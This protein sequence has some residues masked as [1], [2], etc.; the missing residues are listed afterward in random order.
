MRRL[1]ATF[2]FLLLQFPLISRAQ[3]ALAVATTS[4]PAASEGVAYSFQLQA[5]GGVPPYTWAISSGA[6]P[7]GLSLSSGGLI[8]GTPTSGGAFNFTVTVTDSSS[9]SGGNSGGGGSS[10]GGSSG[11]GGEPIFTNVQGNWGSIVTSG[12]TFSVTLPSA[13]TPGNA[14]V[15]AIMEYPEQMTFRIAD[16]ATIPNTYTVTPN[17]PANPAASGAAGASLAYLLNV[18]SGAGATITAT[19]L[20]GGPIN[21]TTGIGCEEYQRSSGTWSFDSDVSGCGNQGSCTGSGSVPNVPIITPA[22]AGELLFSTV[23]V[24]GDHSIA[25]GTAG[26][27]TQASM[28]IASNNQIDSQYVLSSS[29]SATP[30]N[31]TA[32]PVSTVQWTAMAMALK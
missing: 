24:R 18:P 29:S 7:A 1:V 16:N 13:P 12:T 23:N 21:G 32:S 20:T 9:G 15:C 27:W 14:V 19:V 5:T 10:G 30:I 4:L 6:L 26:A 17:S 8:A 25:T 11:G 3:S 22:G 31:Y 28:G 2:A